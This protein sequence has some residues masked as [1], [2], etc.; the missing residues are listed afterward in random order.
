[1]KRMVVALFISCLL[2]FNGCSSKNETEKVGTSSLKTVE[3]LTSSNSDTE[4]SVES[5]IITQNNSSNEMNTID[6]TLSPEEQVA[7]RDN[8]FTLDVLKNYLDNKTLDGKISWFKTQEIKDFIKANL[9]ATE[10]SE[11]IE[12]E[13]FNDSTSELVYRYYSDTGVG[14][15][16]TAS[17]NRIALKLNGFSFSDNSIV[18]NNWLKLVLTS[19]GL[20][21][22][23]IESLI[24]K[25]SENLYTEWIT[26]D[27]G[28]YYF[29][30]SIA[31][32]KDNAELSLSFIDED[33]T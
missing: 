15:E 4:E 12:K 2:V 3:L 17:N 7:Q 32:S 22:S 11:F 18:I 30:L 1:M 16:Y 6:D 27:N 25:A 33:V 13:A 26:T 8:Y 5:E 24:N 21:N 10:Y 9:S 31:S 28:S 23:S 29:S 14:I 19:M 20:D